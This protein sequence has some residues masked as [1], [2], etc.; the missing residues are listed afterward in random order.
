ML[1]KVIATMTLFYLCAFLGCA[2][3]QTRIAEGAGI[4]GVLGAAAGSIIGYQTHDTMTGALIGGAVGAAG[5][6]AIGAQIPKTPPVAQ[7]N[8]TVAAVAQV[9]IKQIV[10]WTRDGISGDI[11][12]QRIQSTHSVYVLTNDDLDYLRKQGVSQRVIEAMQA[13]R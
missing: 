2:E 8:P 5:G 3:N 11:I 1:T 12:I 6:A 4:G 10:D 13:T 7:T 9:S